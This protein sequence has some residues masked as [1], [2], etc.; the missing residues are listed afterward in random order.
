MVLEDGR[1]HV[2][3]LAADR[4]DP[5]DALQFVTERA[6]RRRIPVVIDGASPAASLVPALTVA[7]VKTVITAARDMARACGGL[8]DDVV[9]G[10]L[11]AQMSPDISPC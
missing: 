11:S 1:V 10:R 7:K 5:I 2:E 3:L 9:A 4:C 8:V 6:A